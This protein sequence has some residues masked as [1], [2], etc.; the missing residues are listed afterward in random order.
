M[1]D[2]LPSLRIDFLQHFGPGKV[3]QAGHFLCNQRINFTL[4]FE[5]TALSRSTIQVF[6]LTI[7]LEGERHGFHIVRNI[8]YLN[9]EISLD[10]LGVSRT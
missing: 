9:C 4:Y 5:I 2:R 10:S 6:D 1:C 7:Y 3:A 8:L